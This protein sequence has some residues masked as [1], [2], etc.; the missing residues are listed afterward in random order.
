M[1]NVTSDYIITLPPA[2]GGGNALKNHINSVQKRTFLQA[3]A[4][5][6]KQRPSKLHRKLPNF[7]NLLTFPPLTGIIL[8]RGVIDDRKSGSENS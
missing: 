6:K 3:K 2:A 7:T 4:A 8:K 1:I 5:V